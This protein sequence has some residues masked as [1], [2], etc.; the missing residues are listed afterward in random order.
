METN[1]HGVFNVNYLPETYQ[2]VDNLSLS[3]QA[4]YVS[5]FPREKQLMC[6]HGHWIHS[7]AY[8]RHIYNQIKDGWYKDM[9]L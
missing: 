1:N 5:N 2:V 3:I 6:Y 7:D 8:F 9:A 4:D